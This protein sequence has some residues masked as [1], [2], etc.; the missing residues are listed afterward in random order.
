MNAFAGLPHISDVT[1]RSAADDALFA[2]LAAVLDRHGA[3]DRFGVTLLHTH[4]P[5]ADGEVL[6]EATDEDAR[7]QTLTPV[8]ERPGNVIETVWRL[9]PGGKAMAH[10]ICPEDSKGNHMGTHIKKGG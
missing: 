2:D 6:L 1:P 8:M 4:Y 7:V 3:L 9:G 10:C 5:I